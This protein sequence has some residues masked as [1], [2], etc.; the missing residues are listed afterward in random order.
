VIGYRSQA[1]TFIVLAV[2]VFTAPLLVFAGLLGRVKNQA[3]LDYGALTGRH[4]RLV[5]DRWIHGRAVTDP[6]L[7]APELGPLVDVGAAYAAITNM[8]T[9]PLGKAGLVPIVVAAVLPMLALLAL[10]VPVAEIVKNLLA[11]MV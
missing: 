11:S 3:L 2:V 4:G 1:I 7:Q 6:V 9:V 5:A 10:Q 8:R